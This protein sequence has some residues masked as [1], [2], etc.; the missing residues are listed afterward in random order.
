MGA[1][2]RL[3]AQMSSF[4]DV[5]CGEPG[6]C[7]TWVTAAHEP[8]LPPAGDE[9]YGKVTQMATRHVDSRWHKLWHPHQ[10][11][12]TWDTRDR[13]FKLRG[14]ERVH[15]PLYRA[16][17]EVD[18]LLM[19][20]RALPLLPSWM[21]SRRSRQGGRSRVLY[22]DCGV[23]KRG[24]Q[25]RKVHEWLHD[26]CDLSILGFEANPTSFAEG[27][28][29]LADLSDLDL[30]QVA[31]VGPDVSGDHV[32]LY[33]GT[34][35]A[36]GDSL[37]SERGTSS[38]DVP[39]ERLSKILADDYP[40]FRDATVLLRM[41][42]EGAELFVIEDLVAAGITDSVDGY[43]GMWDDLSKIDPQRDEVFR[44][45]I[46]ARRIHTTSFNDRDMPYAL[47]MWA[48]KVA[49]EAAI[50]RTS[51]GPASP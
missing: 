45:L 48:V 40:W 3:V 50:G 32:T 49:L 28:A 44:E 29:A 33:V 46:D 16:L 1:L 5:R 19:A 39:A 8:A 6:R 38:I 51:P 34:G 47:R 31:L 27:S 37:F 9:E 26:Q 42:I 20:A 13:I 23:H 17:I 43:F 18:S 2:R 21:R 36:K 35:D 22:I 14:G 12:W 11:L 30:R 25:V 7:H 24:E 4:G 10:K 41:N 15:K